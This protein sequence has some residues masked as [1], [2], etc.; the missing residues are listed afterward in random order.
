M[1]AIVLATVLTGL[2]FSKSVRTF[3]KEAYK[4]DWLYAVEGV[5][6]KRWFITLFAPRWVISVMNFLVCKRYP[7]QRRLHIWKL[8]L[9]PEYHTGFKFFKS[10]YW[11]LKI[12]RHGYYFSGLQGSCTFSRL[13]FE[14]KDTHK[15]AIVDI[16]YG[17]GEDFGE[18][19]SGAFVHAHSWKSGSNVTLHRWD[20]N[21]VY[22]RE[23]VA[24]ELNNDEFDF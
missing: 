3:W 21:P 9:N 6:Q 23:N 10:F 5:S 7:V 12:Y 4:I 2:V 13:N 17:D 15:V 14:N 19:K 24:R 22:Q 20:E 8:R 1:L 18:F 16:D 11:Y